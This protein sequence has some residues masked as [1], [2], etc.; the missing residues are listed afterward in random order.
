MKQKQ[1]TSPA[2][3]VKKFYLYLFGILT[4]LFVAAQLN[5]HGC[6][7]AAL[8]TLTAAFG[9]LLVKDVRQTLSREP[10][11]EAE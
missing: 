5:G 2:V 4:L 1:H 9:M 10:V 11:E 3:A 7:V 6:H 8:A